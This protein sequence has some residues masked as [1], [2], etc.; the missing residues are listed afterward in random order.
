MST[1]QPGRHAVTVIA[2]EV[3]ESKNKG[4]PGVFFTFRDAGGDTI[5][6]TLWLSENAFERSVNTLRTAFGFD[7]NFDTIAGQLIDKECSITV[8]MED[9]DKGREW[10]RVK[11]INPARSAAS[12]P[13]AGGLL[14]R[15]SAQAKR[16]AKPEGFTPPPRQ[17]AR[18][19][20]PQGNI[21]AADVPF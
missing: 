14:A 6:G 10:P 13:A 17:P 9:D 11:W 4:T 18:A 8:E 15:L 1:I 16:T 20:A 2:A 7:D 19:P 3:G 5:E 12:K 21:N